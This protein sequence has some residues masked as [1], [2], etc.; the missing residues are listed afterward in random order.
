MDECELIT[1]VTVV[2]CAISKSCSD[3]DIS[4]LS[5]IFTQLGDTLA[6]ILTKREICESKVNG[7]TNNNEKKNEKNNEKNNECN[8]VNNIAEDADN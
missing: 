4:I 6:T 2:A 8:N 7:N 1:F 3:D 5:A